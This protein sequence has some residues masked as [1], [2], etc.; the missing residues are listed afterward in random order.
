[1]PSARSSSATAVSS[2]PSL[3]RLEAIAYDFWC[4][5]EVEE[6]D[7][8]R[9]RFGYGVTGR[10]NSVWPNHDGTMPL[11][12]K[13]ERAEQWYA[14][15][16]RPTLFQVTE[17]ARPEGLSDVLLARGYEWRGVPVSVETAP[18]A[19][20]TRRSS[21]DAELEGEPDDAWVELWIG[22]RRFDR[23]DIARQILTSSPGRT[24]FARIGDLAVGRGV[25]VGEWLGITSMATV[26]A[27]RRRGHARAIVHA[28]ARWAAESGARQALLQV[29]ETN[30]V[31]RRLY[32]GVGFVPSHSYRY[33]MER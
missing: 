31:A 28:L 27:A 14:E 30:V 12:D 13:L 9:L 8:W 4:A 22:T 29:E 16:G 33:C 6:L 7:G 26:P 15:R 21:G 2:T 18:V 1:M 25:V 10:A 23:A 11:A 5:P 32:A 20:I 17:A 19:E 3:S 24:T